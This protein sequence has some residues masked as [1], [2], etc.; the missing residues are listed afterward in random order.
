MYF[1]L[2]N[3][4]ENH[5][6]SMLLFFSQVILISISP[7]LS[8]FH[9]TKTNRSDSYYWD[10]WETSL[11]LLILMLCFHFHLCIV[12]V[13]PLLWYENWLQLNLSKKTLTLAQFYTNNM[14][15][16]ARANETDEPGE[17]RPCL[18]R[19]RRG[20]G[21]AVRHTLT[22]IKFCR[23]GKSITRKYDGRNVLIYWTDA[24]VSSTF[25]CQ[26]NGIR[27]MAYKDKQATVL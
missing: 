1:V 19:S 21:Q 6:A 4:V 17:S 7:V 13:R 2:L 9:V 16:L 20:V 10:F 25:S 5:F 8:L 24:A 3:K 23:L 22:A 26:R 27:P 11:S 12:I 15:N 18:V 14:C